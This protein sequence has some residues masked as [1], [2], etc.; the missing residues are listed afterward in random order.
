MGS[1]NTTSLFFVQL[2]YIVLAYLLILSITIEHD[3]FTV[4]LAAH[5]F[6]LKNKS[7]CKTKLKVSVK[8][9]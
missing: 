5:F 7:I 8:L 6:F 2:R 4:S 3:Y 1:K 9:S